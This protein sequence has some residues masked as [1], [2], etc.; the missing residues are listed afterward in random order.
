MGSGS[1]NVCLGL[2]N[3]LKEH[4]IET[5]D[6]RISISVIQNSVNESVAVKHGIDISYHISTRKAHRKY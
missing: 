1:A 4:A 5:S 6:L 3:G 2:S